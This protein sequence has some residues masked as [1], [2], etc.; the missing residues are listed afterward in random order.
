MKL[1]ITEKGDGLHIEAESFTAA[2][3]LEAAHACFEAA[4]ETVGMDEM[5]TEEEVFASL[6]ETFRLTAI[7]LR[8]C[9]DYVAEMP[10]ETTH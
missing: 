9:N 10:V 6:P 4:M 2:G 3:L 1:T 5:L 7:L 8:D